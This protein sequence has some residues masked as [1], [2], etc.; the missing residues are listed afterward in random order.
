MGQTMKTTSSK[1]MRSKKE[2]KDP[3]AV[4][5]Q[6]TADAFNF[7]NEHGFEHVSTSAH[8]PECEIKYQNET[9]GL[10][11]TY[12]WGG[13]AWVDL[14]RLQRTSAEVVEDERYSLDVLMLECC[15]NRDINEF[16][17]SEDESPD[18]YVERVLLDYAQVL[19]ECGRDILRGDFR[20]FPKLKK[21][22]ENV[23]RQR[24]KELF[25]S[26]TGVI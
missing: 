8:A 18:Q 17:P 24:N 23:L 10:T 6:A 15:P 5:K 25:G 7:L 16:Y 26:E 19:K 14:S 11:I 22:A 4:F 12:E 3:F 20:L 13:V 1:V 2:L 9:T 21:H